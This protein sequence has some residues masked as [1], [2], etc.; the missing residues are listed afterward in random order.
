MIH[1]D[2]LTIVAAV[3]TGCL[4]QSLPPCAP[5]PPRSSFKTWSLEL[6]LGSADRLNR[7]NRTLRW[8]KATESDMACSSIVQVIMIRANN[9]LPNLIP[10]PDQSGT[11]E[12]SRS[13]TPKMPI[14]T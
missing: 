4:L 10:E 3:E 2:L 5:F 7:F 8:R 11:L 9:I 14:P 6:G 1:G 13:W 12:V